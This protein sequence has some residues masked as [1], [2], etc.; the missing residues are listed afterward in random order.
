MEAKLASS[1]WGRKSVEL[2]LGR[3]YTSADKD[4]FALLTVVYKLQS[5]K[6]SRTIK[7]YNKITWKGV[8]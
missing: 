6:S 4:Y 8:L 3:I 7:D 1:M 5:C 2:P